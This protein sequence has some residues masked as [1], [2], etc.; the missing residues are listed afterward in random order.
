MYLLLKKKSFLFWKLFKLQ[1]DSASAR[2]E[3][4]KAHIY[5]LKSSF[6]VIYPPHYRIYTLARGSDACKGSNGLWTRTLD[7]NTRA[8]LPE[9]VVWTMPGPP[10]QGQHRTEDK[11]HTPSPRMEIKI[12]DPA[13]NRNRAAR[14]EVR[15]SINHART[16]DYLLKSRMKNKKILS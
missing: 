9:C 10:S 2:P 3:S 6:S 5:L 14:L 11:G 13:E 8:G 15:D 1:S 16:T 12:P 7:R 4:A